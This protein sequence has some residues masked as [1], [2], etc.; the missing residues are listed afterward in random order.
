MSNRN[1]LL[2]VEI[3]GSVTINDKTAEVLG[4]ILSYDFLEYFTK[5]CSTK[6]D[7]DTMR[8]V[9]L[10]LKTD[11]NKILLARNAAVDAINLQLRGLNG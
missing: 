5:H 7:Y 8:D 6:Y 10:S 4:H 1:D 11:I 9:T 2:K 3:K